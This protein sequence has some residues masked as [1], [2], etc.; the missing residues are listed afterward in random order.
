MQ[1]SG[2]MKP[3]RARRVW[4]IASGIVGLFALAAASQLN[5]QA[6]Q[7]QQPPA[8]ASTPAPAATTDTSSAG[9][10]AIVTVNG[11]DAS[12]NPTVSGALEISG[13][14]AMIVASGSITAGDRTTTVVLP[15]RGTL[16]VCASTTVNLAADSSMPASDAPG[17]LMAIDHGAIETSYATGQNADIILTP[18]FRILIGGS[19]A[20][21]LKVRLG[22]DGD[23]CVDNVGTN[24]PYVVVTS[25]F[26]GG[27][28]RVQPGQRVM[29]QH[30]SLSQVVDNEKEPCGCPP[31]PS[32][33]SGNEF[34]LAQSEGLAPTPAIAPTPPQPADI[35]PA[36]TV[37]LVHNAPDAATQTVP[38]PPAT[39]QASQTSQTTTSPG[40]QKKKL[41]F[42]T[43]VG[44]FFKKIFGA[45]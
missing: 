45:E 27:L 26:E 11:P 24:A 13:G 33:A 20:S 5:A 14:K 22:D 38:V 40:P 32:N 31:S 15:H 8:Q 42:F 28:Y 41:G 23:T 43:R 29:F 10:I 19:G 12:A 37:P 4:G 3:K 7:V 36:I 17:M 6:P 35:S 30:G 18:Q 34:P 2:E 39:L 9:P 16:R 44:N 21:E 1:R 25:L